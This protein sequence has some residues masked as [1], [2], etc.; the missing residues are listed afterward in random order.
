[1]SRMANV[2]PVDFQTAKMMTSS[3]IRIAAPTG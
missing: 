2:R 3:E 1:M